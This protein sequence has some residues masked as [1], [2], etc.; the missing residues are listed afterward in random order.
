MAALGLTALEIGRQIGVSKA[1]VNR[2]F[3]AGKLTK[4]TRSVKASGAVASPLPG[5]WAKAVRD[6]YSLDA[7]DEQLVTCAQQALDVAYDMTET[8][9]TRMNA[10]GRFQALVKQLALVP[11]SA[12]QPQQKPAEPEKPAPRPM[13]VRSGVDPRNVLQAVK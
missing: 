6:T 1:A 9:T 2:W 12:E 13:T 10:M 4:T 8:P 5:E 11:R 3:A 7:T